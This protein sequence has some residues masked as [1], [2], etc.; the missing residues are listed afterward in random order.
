MTRTK[1]DLTTTTTSEKFDTVFFALDDEQQEPERAAVRAKAHDAALLIHHVGPRCLLHLTKS[2]SSS[3]LSHWPCPRAQCPTNASGC[4]PQGSSLF[5]V[6]NTAL[7]CCSV[8][9]LGQSDSCSPAGLIQSA[10][11]Q[12]TDRSQPLLSSGCLIWERGSTR[13]DPPVIH[14][15]SSLRS[16]Q[17]QYATMTMT[18]RVS[19]SQPT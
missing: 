15:S 4:L 16:L 14:F 6:A 7:M 5:M 8:A 1:P 2:R 13:E 3:S 18:A 11:L 9:P 19:H 10:S 17:L 12:L